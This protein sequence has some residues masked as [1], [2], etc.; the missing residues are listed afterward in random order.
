[1]V[2]YGNGVTNALYAATLEFPVSADFTESV[3]QN[4]QIGIAFSSADCG[5][6]VLEGTTT[7][8]PEPGMFPLLAT[9]ATMLAGFGALQRKRA[10]RL[11][12]VR[13]SRLPS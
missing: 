11:V 8:A 12:R 10:Q 2:D 9:G 6:D 3:I 4:D 5:N 1:V 13:A 7:V